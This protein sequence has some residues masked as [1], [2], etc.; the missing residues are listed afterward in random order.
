MLFKPI[1]NIEDVSLQVDKR[2]T[3]NRDLH[4]TQCQ[5]SIIVP[6]KL[7]HVVDARA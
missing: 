7:P 5:R 1:A 3:G 6:Y 4:E 2:L